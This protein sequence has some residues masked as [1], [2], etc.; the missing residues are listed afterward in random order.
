[1]IGKPHEDSTHTKRHEGS[2]PSK[3]H[4]DSTHTKLHEGST[5]TKSHE[6]STHKKTLRV[7]DRLGIDN[8]I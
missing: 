6:D 7:F 2:T 3:S 4:E 8:K 1:M 5:H